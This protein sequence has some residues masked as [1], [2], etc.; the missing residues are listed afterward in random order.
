[1][2]G[3]K[4]RKALSFRRED[5]QAALEL[6]LVLPFFV[7]FLALLVDLGILMYEFVSISNAAREGARYGAVNC[8]TGTCSADLVLGRTVDR[9]GGILTGTNPDDVMSVEWLDNADPNTTN[10]DKGDSVVVSI[11]HPYHFLFFPY[12]INV[13]SCSDMRLEQADKGTGLP[14]GGGCP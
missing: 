10:S 12:T 2:L 4:Q 6:M 5:G 1:M 3:A 11:D 7:M 8:E 14:S 9:S 13:K